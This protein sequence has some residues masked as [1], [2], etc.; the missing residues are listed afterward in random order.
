MNM[1]SQIVS[2]DLGGYDFEQEAHQS[3]VVLVRFF[4]MGLFIAWLCCTH[5]SLIFPGPGC[6]LVARNAFDIGMR[7]GDIG[8]FVV[9]ALFARR[10]GVLSTH[11]S[12]CFGLA[13]LCAI[14]SAVC[15]LYAIP[16]ASIPIIYAIA[17]PTAIGGALLFCLWGQVYCRMGIT[18]AIIDGAISCV[19]AFIVSCFVS[20]MKEPFAVLMTSALPL[21]SMVCVALCLRVLPAEAPADKTQRYPMPW[22]L[23]A[24]MT[25]GSFIMGTS[26]MFLSNAD[27]MGSIHRILA[28]GA[29][30]VVVLGM[31]Y[32]HRDKLDARMLAMVALGLAL[33]SLFV[34][35]FATG[36]LGNVISFT[37]K[38]AFVFFTFFVLLVIVGI[39]RRYDVPSLRLFAVTRICTEGPLLLGLVF[40]RTMLHLELLDNMVVRIALAL[41]GLVLVLV[42]VLIWKS[43]RFVNA[44]WGAQGVGIV[45][46]QHVPGPHEI[47]MTKCDA[48]AEK[49]SLTK[50]EIELLALTLQGKTRTQIEQELYLSGNTVKTHLRHAYGKLGVHSKAEAA[51]IFEAVFGAA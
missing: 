4:G 5:I 24:I 31:A 18:Q 25:I 13:T 7:I 22:K 32:L 33:F 48:L 12:A 3:R 27:Y 23:L 51:E 35:P 28:T 20:F 16:S 1:P 49:Y 41:A 26:S 8:T 39:V 40:S 36:A 6:D 2:P 14:G 9:L 43:E 10:I 30:G 37:E 17:I 21:C 15:G 44:D 11:P 50:R 34:V 45:S 42:C 38:F 29:F 46:K 47:F 19:V